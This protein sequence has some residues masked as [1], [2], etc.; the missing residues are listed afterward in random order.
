MYWSSLGT[1]DAPDQPGLKIQ[2]SCFLKRNRDHTQVW[3]G[4]WN[5]K[6]VCQEA[7]GMDVLS[8]ALPGG[9]HIFHGISQP[10]LSADSSRQ[11]NCIAVC[12]A[13]LLMFNSH[14][15]REV[16]RGFYLPLNTCINIPVQDLSSAV[17]YRQGQIQFLLG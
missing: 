2:L 5:E 9:S 7:V 16:L 14:H 1:E 4:I 15:L 12:C 17:D 8:W 13:V 10:P 6:S 11:H 3:E